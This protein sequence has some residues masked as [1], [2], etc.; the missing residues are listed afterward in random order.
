MLP[1]FSL[2][3]VSAVFF[4]GSDN[5]IGATGHQW[6]TPNQTHDIFEGTEQIQQMVISRALVP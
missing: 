2:V 5:E 3:S 4:P 1:A 6:T